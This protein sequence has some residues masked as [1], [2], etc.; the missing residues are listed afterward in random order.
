MEAT[1][2]ERQRTSEDNRR[3]ASRVLTGPT[4]LRASLVSLVAAVTLLA[5]H[6]C[7]RAIRGIVPVAARM[8]SSPPRVPALQGATRIGAIEDA[9][10]RAV[11]R[12]RVPYG[13][14]QAE[15]LISAKMRSAGWKERLGAVAGGGLGMYSNERGDW[16][17]ISIE[18]AG[19]EGAYVN[20]ISIPSRRAMQR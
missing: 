17:T 20:V 3:T 14:G 15:A 7:G 1:A 13:P 19:D 10:A 2:I 18:P 12:Y 8:D 9:T 4:I 5:G 6:F 11:Q 16:C